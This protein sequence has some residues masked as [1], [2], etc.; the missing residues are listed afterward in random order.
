MGIVNPYVAAP[1]SRLGGVMLGAL[2][3][4]TPVLPGQAASKAYVDNFITLSVSPLSSFVEIVARDTDTVF[5]DNVVTIRNDLT[6]V[7]ANTGGLYNDGYVG[8]AAFRFCAPLSQGGAEFPAFGFSGK[9][10]PNAFAGGASYWEISNLSWTANPG[11]YP[12][13]V[14]GDHACG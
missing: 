2:G 6:R 13:C 5:H 7:S 10:S 3:V 4:L 14:R 12:G 9:T 8:N 11:Y 1:L